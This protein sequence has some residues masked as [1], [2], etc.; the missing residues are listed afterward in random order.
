VR[1]SEEEEIEIL[2]EEEKVLHAE[3]IDGVCKL[4]MLFACWCF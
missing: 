1:E 3:A 2:P 4:W